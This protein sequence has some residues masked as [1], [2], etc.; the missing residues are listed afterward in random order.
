[1]SALIL[2]G[3]ALSLESEADLTQR[4]EAIKEQNNGDSDSQSRWCRGNTRLRPLAH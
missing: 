2:D 3:K 4:V 1:M